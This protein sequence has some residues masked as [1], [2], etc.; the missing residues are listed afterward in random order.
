MNI[1]KNLTFS[2]LQYIIIILHVL[3]F[4]I[5]ID[6]YNTFEFFYDL[7]DHS[8]SEIISDQDKEFLHFFLNCLEKTSYFAEN[9]VFKNNIP[10]L[11]EILIKLFWKN[12]VNNLEVK[13]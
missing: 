7:L 13:E 12:S 1:N 2:F 3:D 4:T 8:E 11:L 9:S 5:I 6:R 10:T